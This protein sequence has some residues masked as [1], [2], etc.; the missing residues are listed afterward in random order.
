[1]S[2]KK[3]KKDKKIDTVIQMALGDV[4]LCPLCAGAAIVQKI[5]GYPRTTANTPISATMI[6]NRIMHITSQNVI[7]AL[8]DAVVAI[9]EH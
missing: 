4:K 3:Q 7:D 1:L 9:G 5:R 6:N 2:F 8:Q